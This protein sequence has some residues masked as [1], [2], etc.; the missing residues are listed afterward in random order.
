MRILCI[1]LFLHF[2]MI[3]L[4]AQSKGD[5]EYVENTINIKKSEIIKHEG[6]NFRLD[7]SGYVNF[8]FTFYKT[9]LSSQDFNSCIYTP[10]CSSYALYAIRQ[11][12]MIKGGIMTFDRLTRCNP[13]SVK[14]YEMD[15]KFKKLKDPVK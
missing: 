10:S 7:Y 9:F 14:H 8:L 5:L 3:C 11:N 6:Q 15:M 1:L 13:A 2:N 4:H 12:G